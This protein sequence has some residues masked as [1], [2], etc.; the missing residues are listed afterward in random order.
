MTEVLL[1]AER[2][3]SHVQPFSGLRKHL[4]V[5]TRSRCSWSLPNDCFFFKIK[6]ETQDQLL[7][8]LNDYHPS[9]KYLIIQSTNAQALNLDD[10]SRERSVLFYNLIFTIVYSVKIRAV[11]RG[12]RWVCRHP[13]TCRKGPL[14][15][16]GRVKMTLRMR[17]K[18]ISTT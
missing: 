1:K 7:D 9:T 12:K 6:R 3:M 11:G 15:L 4:H 2:R 17:E 16:R 8:R 18:W 13:L 5:K 10:G 14:N